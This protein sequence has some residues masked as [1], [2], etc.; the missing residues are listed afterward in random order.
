MSEIRIQTADQWVQVLRIYEITQ[1]QFD[2]ITNDVDSADDM[3]IDS[4]EYYLPGRSPVLVRDNEEVIDL[5]NKLNDREYTMQ[6][7]EA[8]KLYFVKLIGGKGMQCASSDNHTEEELIKALSLDK[9]R[10]LF[11]TSE[12][13]P[14]INKGI[15][16]YEISFDLEHNELEEVF[17]WKCVDTYL[18]DAEGNISYP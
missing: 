4:E 17:E 9:I 10:I 14:E 5:S 13:Y 11:G 2:E 12:E 3:D 7:N 18:V 8:G 1:D 6:L 15:E 16:S